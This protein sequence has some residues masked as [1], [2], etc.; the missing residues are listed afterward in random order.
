MQGVDAPLSTLI[1]FCIHKLSNWCFV[2]VDMTSLFHNILSTSSSPS[3]GEFTPSISLPSMLSLSDSFYFFSFFLLTEFKW[4]P[5]GGSS[6][7]LVYFHLP[8]QN[9]F[10]LILYS[11][12]VF[13]Y[14]Y[15][16]YFV[17]SCIFRICISTC[18]LFHTFYFLIVMHHNT[19]ANS[20]LYEQTDSAVDLI[21]MQL[22]G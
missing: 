2:A 12:I 9:I 14:L 8:M 21:L 20:L 19:K 6:M 3:E 13:I 5:G 11:K 15:Q 4:C 7:L 16:L 1:V 22:V 10:L 18:F 17:V